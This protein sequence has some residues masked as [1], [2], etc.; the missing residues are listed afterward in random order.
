MLVGVAQRRIV[1][2]RPPRRQIGR[3]A[4]GP[5]LCTRLAG[6]VLGGR[7]DRPATRPRAFPQRLGI[8]SPLPGLVRC[9]GVSL[10]WIWAPDL[11]P[12]GCGATRREPPE[13]SRY[14]RRHPG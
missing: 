13:L 7:A 11:G 14:A 9:H 10:L 3:R 4:P 2:G 12:G 8:G 6:L 5:S 1:A